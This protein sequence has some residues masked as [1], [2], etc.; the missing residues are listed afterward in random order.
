M[1]QPSPSNKP[2][3]LKDYYRIAYDAYQADCVRAWTVFSVMSVLNGALFVTLS[4]AKDGG[5][6]EW[7]IALVGIFI[8]LIW[9]GTQLRFR[10]WVTGFR[11][12]L[13]KIERLYCE[14]LNNN[15]PSDKQCE[16]LFEN[17]TPEGALYETGIST[18]IAAVVLPCLLIFLWV[19]ICIR[20]FSFPDAKLPKGGVDATQSVMNS[21]SVLSPVIN[22]TVITASSPSNEPSG[23]VPTGNKQGATK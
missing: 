15:R 22:I 9:A 12:R 21:G 20:G 18:S 7:S 13:R 23:P 6:P 1:C 17:R 3:S 19:Y 8:C 2:D 4:K 14:E 5:A 11:E 16:P 10:Y